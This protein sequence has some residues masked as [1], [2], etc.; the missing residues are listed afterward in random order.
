MKPLQSTATLLAFAAGALFATADDATLKIGDAAPKLQVAKWAQGEPV[1][2]FKPGTT[3]LVEF[4]ATWCGPCRQSIP[5][6]NEIHNRFKDKGLVVIG[7]DCWEQH[8]TLVAPF[9]E[10]M[11][12]K[13]TYRVAIDDKE[14]N[15]KGKMA[16]TWM[17]A[18]GQK[19]IPT[20]FLVDPKG[21]IAWIGHPMSLQDEVL[22]QVMAG[23]WDIAKAS[24]EFD[25]IRKKD[26]EMQA[27][28]TRFNKD[29]SNKNWDAAMTAL[30]ELEKTTPEPQRANL[31]ITRFKVM[32][33]KK[34]FAA[35]NKIAR[36]F[37]DANKDNSLLQNELAWEI[38]TNP[39]ITERDLSL[40][41]LIATR[42]NDAARGKDP[43]I[44]DTLARVYFM[45]GRKDEAISLQQKALDQADGDMKES[46]QKTLDAYKQGHLPKDN[47]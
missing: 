9:I 26:E 12:E 14:G 4:W 13:M 24:A 19:G 39:N 1:A 22:E 17:A 20:A 41:E 30:D 11:G 23:T 25:K 21:K 36:Q 29:V 45:Q 34:D 35:A 5:H 28:W 3:Y 27:F 37:S 2:D 6:L 38:A 7:Q 43:G 47:T 31:E 33:T 40:A 46:L 44:M 16:E 15:K 32:V 8:E 42:A 18:A 10:K